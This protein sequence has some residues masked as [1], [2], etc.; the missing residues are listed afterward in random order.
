MEE[1]SVHPAAALFPMLGEAALAELAEDIK[2]N[3]LIH[4]VVIDD[5][6]RVLDGRNRLAACRLAGVQP[7]FKPYTGDDPLRFVVSENV[8]RRHLTKPQLAVSAARAWKQA[9]DEGRTLKSGETARRPSSPKNGEDDLITDARSHFGRLFGVSKTYVEMARRVLDYSPALAEEVAA[10]QMTLDQAHQQATEADRRKQREVDQL[11][12]LRD[13]APDLVERIE[14]DELKIAEAEAIHRER[15]REDRERRR[16][17]YHLLH[18]FT[19]TI[20]GVSAA[21]VDRL[22]ELLDV[23]E[24]ELEFR[25]FFRGGADEFV[26]RLGCLSDAVAAVRSLKSEITSGR[27]RR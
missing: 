6:G 9:D 7:H 21:P 5:E 11:E 24:F 15:D 4:A 2:A 22:P 17:L 26:E 20:N 27:R 14:R 8:K 19:R 3:G 18:D 1:L 12:L 13:R 25:E 10:G 23:K 16:T